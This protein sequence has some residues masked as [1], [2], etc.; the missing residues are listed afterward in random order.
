MPKEDKE[1]K[2]NK[3]NIFDGIVIQQFYNLL[4]KKYSI[5][6]NIPSLLDFFTPH[7]VEPP[8]LEW[9]FNLTFRAGDDRIMYTKLVRSFRNKLM[10]TFKGIDSNEVSE[11][12]DE[13]I[14]YLEFVIKKTDKMEQDYKK[15]KY[16]IG[17]KQWFQTYSSDYIDQVGSI[18]WIVIRYNIITNPA[19]YKEDKYISIFGNDGDIDIKPMIE[20]SDEILLINGKSFNIYKK[21]LKNYFKRKYEDLLKN[22][23][24]NNSNT[25]WD[26]KNARHIISKELKGMCK[27][28]NKRIEEYYSSY[29]HTTD[30]YD[31]FEKFENRKDKTITF[32]NKLLENYLDNLEIKITEDINRIYHSNYYPNRSFKSKGRPKGSVDPKV[33]NRNEWIVKYHNKLEKQGL[34]GKQKWKELQKQIRISYKI[35]LNLDYIQNIYYKTRGKMKE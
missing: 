17:T 20:I 26:Y 29:L 27:N 16:L 1:I 34:K 23:Y 8:M 22:H 32:N 7:F 4:D 14:D 6:E 10:D 18:A 11:A 12:I 13:I 30:D 33:Q 2:F 3:E 15:S 21:L 5:E 24:P 25:K 35:D 31:K 19:Y 28:I 9:Y